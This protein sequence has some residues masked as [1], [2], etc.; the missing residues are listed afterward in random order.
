MRTAINVFRTYRKLIL[1]IV[2][3]LIVQTVYVYSTGRSPVVLSDESLY[4][5]IARQIAKTGVQDN[6]QYPFL[7]PLT[8]CLSLGAG[9]E[10]YSMA[11]AVNI[12]LKTILLLVIFQLLKK[13]LEEKICLAALVLIAFSPIYFMW[14]RMIMAENLM[15]PLFVITVLF[16]Y[17]YRRTANKWN[18]LIAASLALSLWMTKYLAIVLLPFFCIYWSMGG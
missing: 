15:A 3:F 11:L 14:S 12:L 8:V 13:F 1:I 7:Y 6:F 5:R 17:T 4:V 16:H 2:C 9:R 10:L 18:T